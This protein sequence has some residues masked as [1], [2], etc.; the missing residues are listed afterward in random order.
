MIPL[1]V[2]GD[3]PPPLDIR[4]ALATIAGLLA[5]LAVRSVMTLQS[6]GYVPA[7]VAAAAVW[8]RPVEEVRRSAADAVHLAAGMGAGLIFEALIV[9]SERLRPALGIRIEVV[10][11][12]VTTL[13]ELLALAIVVAFIYGFFSRLVFPRFGGTA[14][15]TRPGTVRR[16][17]AVSAIAYAVFLFAALK[18]VYNVLA[19]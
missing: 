3:I 2:P 11:A 5:A 6:Y 15:E 12:G 16:Q 14:Y 17:W 4:L 10:V 1:H 8:R 13:A 18:V 9:A 7:Y 19:V